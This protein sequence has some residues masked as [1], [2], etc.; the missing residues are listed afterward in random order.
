MP[1][2]G[3]A[4]ADFGDD[5]YRSSWQY[6]LFDSNDVY[7]VDIG[8]CSRTAAAWLGPDAANDWN[9]RDRGTDS[10]RTTCKDEYEV[11]AAENSLDLSNLTWM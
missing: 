6:D 8:E 7:D 1:P 9:R 2:P 5:E 3:G 10:Y 4:A 11:N